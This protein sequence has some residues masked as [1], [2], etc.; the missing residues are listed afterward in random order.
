MIVTSTNLLGGAGVESL[1]RSKC[2]CVLKKEVGALGR[3]GGGR[4]LSGGL[5][6]NRVANVTLR[7]N[8]EVIIAVDS[9]ETGGGTT[10]ESGNVGHLRGHFGARDL[11]GRAV[12]DENCGGFLSV[13]KR[14]GIIVSCAG[15]RCS[16]GFSKLGNCIA[17]YDL[18][19]GSVVRGCECL[20][21]VRHTFH[22]GGASLSVHPVCRHLFGH[23]RTRVYVYFATCAVVLRLRHVL[24]TTKAGV[25]LRETEFLA[26]GVCGLRCFGPFDEGGVSIVPGSRG[27][28]RIE[29]LLTVVSTT[30][31][32]GGGRK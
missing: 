15:V 27:S 19:S 23:V 21:V 22:V 11:A 3:D 31:S 32:N 7:P 25:A 4:V 18:P 5:G 30:Y 6:R 14:T 12:G 8:Q 16:T 24:G 29:R 13:R 10:S 1:R 20:F 17:G 2:R 26:R 28:F 9:R